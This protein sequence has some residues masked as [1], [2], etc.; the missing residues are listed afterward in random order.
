MAENRNSIVKTYEKFVTDLPGNTFGVPNETI[1]STGKVWAPT[2]A[3]NC[4]HH[5]I[6]IPV[7][8]CSKGVLTAP[9]TES[10]YAKL[11]VL[12]RLLSAKYLHPEIREKRGAYGGGA[13]ISP[14]GVFSFYS[15]RDPQNLETLNV[16][17]K[18][19]NWLQKELDQITE[20]DVLEAK[21]GVF[22]SVDAPV[23][24]SSKGMRE[25][26]LGITPEVLQRHRAEIMIVNRN[27]LKTV[28]EKYLAKDTPVS[29]SKVILG[30]KSKSLNTSGRTN[31][32][33]TTVDNE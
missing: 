23:P 20:Q 7:H 3:I 33:W 10:D 13:R 16:F 22:Q 11:R 9:Y 17:D 5:V 24:P 29:T 14:D 1:Y 19:C 2:D 18:S 30:P 26:L 4:Q 25:F 15:Y 12:A 21:L 6:N 32:L 28:A 31:E 27:G 8:F